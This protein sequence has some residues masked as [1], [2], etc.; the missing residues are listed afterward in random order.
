MGFKP[1]SGTIQ[2]GR[3]GGRGGGGKERGMTIK[4]GKEKREGGRRGGS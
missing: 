2:V 1:T 4:G 3:E